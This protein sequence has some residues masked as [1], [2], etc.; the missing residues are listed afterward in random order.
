MRNGAE[1]VSDRTAARVAAGLALAATVFCGACA[2]ASPAPPPASSLRPVYD[3]ATGRLTELSLDADGDAWFEF[4]A[5]V[6]GQTIRRVDVDENGDGIP[7]RREHYHAAP[8]TAEGP[9]EPRLKEVEHLDRTGGVTRREGYEEGQLAWA[10]ED[11]NRDGRTDRWETWAAGALSSVT[12][13]RKATDAPLRIVYPV[14]P[15][16]GRSESTDTAD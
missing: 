1:P 12:I 8:S 6:E 14:P 4:K 15:P 9:L 10:Q 11:R 3:P 2:G 5:H 16:E 7:E 13:A